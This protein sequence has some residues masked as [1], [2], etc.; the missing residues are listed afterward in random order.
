[1]VQLII[2]DI[3]FPLPLK[4]FP[5]LVQFHETRKI[6]PFGFAP[7]FQISTYL[8]TLTRFDWTK[9][10]KLPSKIN[11][12]FLVLHLD[13]HPHLKH[14]SAIAITSIYDWALPRFL[15]I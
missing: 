11:T 8:S 10:I 7:E 9:D 2:V 4:R 12:L 1:M 5:C 13:N 14:T 3:T 6:V 15:P